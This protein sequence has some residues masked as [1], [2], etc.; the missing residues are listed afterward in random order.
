MGPNNTPVIEAETADSYEL[1]FKA[2]LGDG[3]YIV[4]GA[5]FS[6][7][8]DNFQANNFLFLNGALITTLTTAG[9]VK[10]EG[11]E[12]EVLAQASD[13]LTFS[14]GIAYADAHVVEFPVPV[15]APPGTNPTVRSG[16]QLPLAPK[17]KASLG[18]QYRFE[19]DSFDFTPGLVYAYQD[20]Q[21]SD[22]NEPAALR[23]DGYGT[24]DL[25][26]TF[27]DKDDRYRLTLVG[28]NIT[29]E[30]FV[31]LRTAGGPGG[32]PRLQIPRDADR[33]FG[34]Q[35]RMNFGGF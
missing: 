6:T 18:G 32:V 13:A 4:S 26:F 5:A 19:F 24:L 3:R 14:A 2:T 10:T 33:Y 8:Y 31:A 21:W 27:A 34:L 11:V 35:F 9:E 7:T 29:D 15:G 16:T 30:Q 17:L 12:L 25:T 20:E 1:G 23:I 22:L 28:R